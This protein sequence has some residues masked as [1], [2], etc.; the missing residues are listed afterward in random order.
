M[1]HEWYH[2]QMLND[3]GRLSKT[4]L[5]SKTNVLYIFSFDA[6]YTCIPFEHMCTVSYSSLS[7]LEHGVGQLSAALPWG[8]I[9]NKLLLSPT[10]GWI[11]AIVY[12][13]KPIT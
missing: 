4:T 5:Q 7:R 1:I 8:H 10:G 13:T 2:S 12:E 6:S 3:L 9:F 11:P